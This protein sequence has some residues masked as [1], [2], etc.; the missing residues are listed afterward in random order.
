M[1][2]NLCEW[3]AAVSRTSAA[4]SRA[5]EKTGR[6]AD[7]GVRSSTW[8]SCTRRGRMDA[9]RRALPRGRA[10]PRAYRRGL[11]PGSPAR[12]RSDSATSRVCSAVSPKPRPTS[13]PHSS[14]P[15]LSTPRREEVLAL[16]FMGELDFDRGH[17]PSARRGAI[18]EALALAAAHGARGRPG[19]G[20]RA[21][22]CGGAARC[23]RQLDEADEARARRHVAG[24][25][26]HRRRSRARHVGYRVAGADRRDAA[27]SAESAVEA[28]D[29]PPSRLLA[30]CR[31]RHE[32]GQTSLLGRWPRERGSAPARVAALPAVRALLRDRERRYG[33]EPPRPNSPAHGW[34]RPRCRCP[35]APTTARAS[36]AATRAEPRGV[37]AGHARRSRRS[38]AAPRPPSCRCS[39]PARPAPARNWW[40]AR[41]TRVGARRASRS[42]PSTAARSA[43]SCSRASCSA[44]ARARSPARTPRA[45][46]WS[47]PR[48]AARCSSTRSARCRSTLQVKLLRVL[49]SGEY[50]R[51]GDDR[52]RD[53]PTCAS[54][55]PPTGPCAA[56]TARSCSAAT[57]CSAS[58][59]SRSGCPRCAIAARTSL[60]L[61]RHFLSFYGGLDGPRPAP[62]PRRCSLA[63]RGRG[64][65][66]ELENVMKRLAGAASGTTA[67]SA[68]GDVLPFL[69]EAA[70]PRLAADR[71]ARPPSG[72]PI[73]AAWRDARGN[74]SRLA[75][76]HRREPQDAL[77]TAQ[78]AESRTLS[79]P[80]AARSPISGLRAP[81]V[82][83]RGRRS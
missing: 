10:R 27:G 71:R 26:S 31:D 4:R 48:T 82:P 9:R 64:N 6:L 34:A 65:V 8:A 45:S 56:S 43:P 50:S 83:A 60:P 81:L 78:A 17:A 55:R 29:A 21:P 66:R 5:I 38:R 13:S 39:S 36:A 44:T 47:K 40:R 75:A 69:T 49:E 51:V 46:G 14:V 37:L 62:T 33:L 42:S 12:A 68:A 57:C 79:P 35:R 74:K 11:R 2:K 19:G 61:A 15:R 3:D 54:S 52:R 20:A 23:S 7:T 70:A 28:L 73:V 32:L 63:T 16:E 76:V 72:T 58:T 80:H 1:H 59:R 41:C 18:N 22:A 53:A 77:R 67:P 25:P 30:E 24:G